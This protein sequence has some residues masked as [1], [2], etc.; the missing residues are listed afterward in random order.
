[1]SNHEVASDQKRQVLVWKPS[2]ELVVVEVLVAGE[3]DLAELLLL[4]LVHVEVDP[5]RR[6]AERLDLEVHLREVVALGAVEALDPRCRF[7]NS[8]G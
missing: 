1:M 7:S 2:R 5:H 6:L 4:A 8:S 3:I